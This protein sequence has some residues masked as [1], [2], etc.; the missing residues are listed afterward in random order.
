MQK[1][2]PKHDAVNRWIGA[3]IRYEWIFTIFSSSVAI[4]LGLSVVGILVATQECSVH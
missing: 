4:I 1:N 2:I 3:I